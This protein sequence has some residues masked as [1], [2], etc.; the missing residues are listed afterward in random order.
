MAM[1]MEGIVNVIFEAVEVIARKN[2]RM[3]HARTSEDNKGQKGYKKLLWS[4]VFNVS[5]SLF[6]ANNDG[7]SASWTGQTVALGDG[8]IQ[9]LGFTRMLS[10]FLSGSRSF[11][12][13]E[14]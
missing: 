8:F 3:P 2:D 5:P 1:L 4:I 7:A 11:I 12:G 6:S 10:S 9:N 13:K 14:R